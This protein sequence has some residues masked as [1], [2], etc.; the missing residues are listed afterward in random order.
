MK[1]F[2][3]PKHSILAIAIIATWI[4]TAI[5]YRTSFDIGY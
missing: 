2:K 1:S 5:V 3:W 4:K